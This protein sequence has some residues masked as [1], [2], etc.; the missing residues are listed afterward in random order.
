MEPDALIERLR[1]KLARIPAD[2]SICVGF[3]G[4]LDST[5]LLHALAQVS[6]SSGQRI[7]ALHVHHGLSPNADAWDAGT[8][9]AVLGEGGDVTLLNHGGHPLLWMSDPAGPGT[10]FV[11]GEQRWSGPVKLQPSPKLWRRQ[12]FIPRFVSLSRSMSSPIL[13]SGLHSALVDI[14]P[15]SPTYGLRTSITLPASDS[16]GGDFHVSPNLPSV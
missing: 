9:V 11:R 6:A 12:D 4:G 16:P 13:N 15:I 3:S 1:G 2:A 7:T 10:L 5:V 8:Q 14:V